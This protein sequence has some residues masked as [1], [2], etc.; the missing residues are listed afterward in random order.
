M[1]TREL[2]RGACEEDYWLLESIRKILGNLATRQAI[3]ELFLK[4]P[5]LH[6]INWFRNEEWKERQQN[7]T[8]ILS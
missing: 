8:T 3:D 1:H 2:F 5:D 6:K 4:N 7:K